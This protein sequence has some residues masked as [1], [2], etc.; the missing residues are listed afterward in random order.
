MKE[1]FF[2]R[3]ESIKYAKE[4]SYK[5]NP[6]YYNYDLIGGD[7][8]NFVSQC[9]YNGCKTMNYNRNNGWY[10]INANQKSPSWTGVEFLYKF[11]INN[12]SEGPYGIE[13]NQSLIEEGDIVQF[14]F[15]GHQFTHSLL[16]VRIINK[17]SFD[18]IFVA[19]HTFDSFDRKISSY[20]FKR[21]RFIHMQG[22]RK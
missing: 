21:I 1:V 16:I 19:S 3:A 20:N 10:Y 7:C 4:W 22:A 5:R 15:D 8:T 17:M 11:L 18:G 9:L 12:K 2:D 6:K 14:S 13:I